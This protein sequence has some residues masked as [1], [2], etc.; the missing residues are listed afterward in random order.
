[1]T[2]ELS[3]ITPEQSLKERFFKVDAKNRFPDGLL[4]SKWGRASKLV[5]WKYPYGKLYKIYFVKTT[6]RKYG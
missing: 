3:V 4:M 5:R 2:Q 6:Y 1:M